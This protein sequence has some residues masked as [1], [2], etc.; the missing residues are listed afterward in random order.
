DRPEPSALYLGKLVV[1]RDRAGTGLGERIVAECER[2]ARERGV[3]CLRLDCIASN[4]SLGRYY[5]RLGYYPRG[6]VRSDDVDLLRHDKRL[7]PIENVVV[8]SL[9][10][11]DFVRWRPDSVATLLFVV[12]RGETL[13]IRKLRGHGAGKINAPGGMVERGETPRACALREI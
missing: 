13:L 10:A 12:R 1:A 8:G 4:E 3:A 7:A 11:V 2:I 5:Q 6:A 9:D